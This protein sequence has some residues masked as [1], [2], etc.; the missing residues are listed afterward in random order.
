MIDLI[1]T[2]KPE[3]GTPQKYVHVGGVF[4][5]SVKRHHDPQE[6]KLGNIEKF[7]T[8]EEGG[9]FRYRLNTGDAVINFE[10]LEKLMIS[11]EQFDPL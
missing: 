10:S 11:S 2:E 6:Q 3:M 7:D 4:K 8:L 9:R 1:I 5:L